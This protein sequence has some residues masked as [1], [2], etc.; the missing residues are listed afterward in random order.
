LRADD[1]RSGRGRLRRLNRCLRV[2]RH[3]AP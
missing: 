3:D 2:P 1:L